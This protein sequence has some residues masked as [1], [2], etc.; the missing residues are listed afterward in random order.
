MQIS[1]LCK[2]SHRNASDK[3]FWK[4]ER[5][6]GT[7][8]M[9]IVSELGEALEADRK[10][11]NA[12]TIK[13][14]DLTQNQGIDFDIAFEECIKDSF[15]DEIADVFIR[16]ADLCEGRD[17]DIETFI[18]LKMEYNKTRGYKHGKKY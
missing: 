17:I 13:F 16:L 18:E 8:L 11:K 2:K 3:G 5:E 9:L 14:N 7:L 6:I 1:E 10:N 15:E 12:A 4:E